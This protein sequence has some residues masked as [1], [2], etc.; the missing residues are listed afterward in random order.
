MRPLAPNA[1]NGVPLIGYSRKL[2]KDIGRIYLRETSY[3]WLLAKGASLLDLISSGNVVEN[4]LKKAFLFDIKVI[5]WYKNSEW[6]YPELEVHK[7]HTNLKKIILLLI[8]V[9]HFKPDGPLQ[10]LLYSF[11]ILINLRKRIELL[12]QDK[13]RNFVRSQNSTKTFQNV[14]GPCHGMLLPA[15]K[16]Q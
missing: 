2:S 16:H 10:E 1:V 3:Y 12:I 4:L 8:A 5:N 6:V 7:N 9:V 13:K 11:T 14:F 15:W